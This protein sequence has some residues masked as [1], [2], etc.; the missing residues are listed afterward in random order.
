MESVGVGGDK[1]WP[2]AKLQSLFLGLRASFL[3]FR[4]ALPVQGCDVPRRVLGA[5][6][7]AEGGATNCSASQVI[8]PYDEEETMAMYAEQSQANLQPTS[9]CVARTG[10]KGAQDGDRQPGSPGFYHLYG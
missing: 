1:I 6:K 7:V 9:K 8:L 10:A 5:R 2:R 4:F 3:H